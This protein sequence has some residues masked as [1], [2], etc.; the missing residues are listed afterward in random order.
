ML[1]CPE[2]AQTDQQ[3]QDLVQNHFEIQKE[4]KTKKKIERKNKLQ[5][6]HSSGPPE[7]E[8][9]EYSRILLDF[10]VVVVPDRFF[11]GLVCLRIT[12]NENKNMKQ[13]GNHN[14][15]IE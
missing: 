12:K 6:E 14:S 9:A 8:L 3:A 5:P 15:K 11:F 4:E 1:E 7:D 2:A 13:T 10:F